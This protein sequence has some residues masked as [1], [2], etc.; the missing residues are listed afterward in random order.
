MAQDSEKP[1]GALVSEPALE[2][3]EAAGAK[4]RELIAREQEG[5][6]LRIRVSGGGCNGLS[7]GLK[8]TDSAKETDHRIDSQGVTLLIDP[9]SLEFL[10]GTTLD[11]SNKMVGGGFKFDNPNAKSG[12]SCGESFSVR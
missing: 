8:F 12:C 5:Q 4:I 11:Y 2:L 9:K 1:A 10:Q 7:Y 6:F 3:T